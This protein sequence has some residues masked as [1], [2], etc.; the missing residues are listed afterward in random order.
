MEEPGYAGLT[1]SH[2]QSLQ[3]VKVS[4]NELKPVGVFKIQGSYSKTWTL[5]QDQIKD[6]AVRPFART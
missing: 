4:L 2:L 1:V 3:P 6:L 5:C